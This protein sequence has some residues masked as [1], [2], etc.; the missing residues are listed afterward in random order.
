MG[1]AGKLPGMRAPLPCLLLAATALATPPLPPVTQTVRHPNA[2][3]VVQVDAR[4]MVA[5]DHDGAAAVLFPRQGPPRVVKFAANGKLRSPLV[6]PQGRV[7]AVGLDFPRCEVAVWDV[8]AGRKVT[9]LRG[10]FTKIFGCHDPFGTEFVLSTVFSPDGRFVFTQDTTGLR[11]WDAQTG[12]LL[13]ARPGTFRN[14]SV[15]PDG[16][17]LFTLG[18]HHRGE[19]WTSDLSRRLKVTPGQPGDCFRGPGAGF[20]E[21]SWSPDSRRLAFSCAR[22][23][24]VWNVAAGGLQ[25]LKR[26]N[27]HD[28]ADTPIFSADGRFVL[29]GEDSA[30]VAV[31]RADT[32]ERVRQ[33]TPPGG[34]AQVTDLAVTPGNV[35]YATLNGGQVIRQSL[36]HPQNAPT[37]WKVFA[38][39]QDQGW[40]SLALSRE[41]DRLAV[42]SG[43]GLLSLYPLQDR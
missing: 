8:T 36:T 14:L 25:S 20:S 10:D 27:R 3:W 41:G 31:W 24:R 33:I 43:D 38:G 7:L 17:F 28:Y 32:G 34:N 21:A 9:A 5:V 23:V 6:T 39:D 19:V 26:E 42:A 11:R 15:S 40:P 4:Q 18:Q 1:M 30:G 2:R 35:L 13:R 29:A 22:E 16:R 37:V 12:K